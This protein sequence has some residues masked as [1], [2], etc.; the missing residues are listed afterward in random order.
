[1]LQAYFLTDGEYPYME[2]FLG[3]MMETQVWVYLD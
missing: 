1:M 2:Q 3:R